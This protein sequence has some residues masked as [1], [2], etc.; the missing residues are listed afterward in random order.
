MAENKDIEIAVKEFGA[1]ASGYDKPLKYYKGEHELAFATEKFQNT[2]GKLFREFA[3]NLCPAVADAVRDKLTLTG[4]S[5]ETGEN[6]SGDITTD[7]WKIWQA[8][9]MGVRSRQIHR[10]ALVAGDSY[11][12]VWVDPNQKTTI[13]PQ[14]AKTC[15]VFYD[16]ESPG[17]ILKAAKQW[18][19]APDAK[20]EKFARIN[21]Y[22][23]DRIER[24]ISVKKTTALPEKATDYVEFK[25]DGNSA[26][27]KNPYGVVPVFH[28]GNNADIGS[29]GQSE[30]A[31][32]IPLQ[33]AL[34]KSVC[35]LLVAMEFAAY[36]QR[37]ATGIDVEYDDEGKPKA[38]FVAGIERLWVNESPEA[39]FGDFA[40]SDLKQFLEVKDGFRVDMAVV[41]GTPI[42]YFQQTGGQ[43]PSG[44]ALQKAE[45]RFNHKVNDRQESF[46][47]V[48]EDLMAFALRIEGN[49]KDVRLFT[50]WEDPAP[51]S[52]KDKLANLSTKGDLG[53]PDEKLW[54]EM[55][56]GE[57]DIK[58]FQEIA[59]Q[60]ALD[61][62]DRFN[63]G[64]G[65]GVSG[66]GSE[67]AT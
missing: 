1:K 29:F 44:E 31:D 22:Y 60:K 37:Y 67:G 64:E 41:T 17:K 50:E 47:Q 40:A 58:R 46:G 26:I 49:K 62:V 32:A 27:I 53:V 51:L 30:L 36:R 23:P 14:K 35:D 52:E 56:Y 57:D 11:A 39:K 3:L 9:R 55:G 6:A 59:A 38:P 63:A 20:G 54:E 5:V 19:T 18:L 42:Y 24:Y 12:I 34:N 43:F 66:R 2:F 33:N 15:V 4:W 7:A 10:E 16:E 65:D 13:Y 28:F 25:D 21:L 45:A 48:W 8:N 61:A